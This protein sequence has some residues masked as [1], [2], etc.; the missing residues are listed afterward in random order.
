M[1]TTKKLPPCRT[2]QKEAQFL[3]EV[4]KKVLRVF[5]LAI[6]WNLY[7]F[8]LRF[9]QNHATSYSFYSSVTVHRKGERRE[10]DRKPY[11]LPY[12]LRNPSRNLKF[13][14]TLKIM[15]RNLNEIQIVLS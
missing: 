1:K 8:A 9:L 3:D 10:P 13:E 6:H 12:G 4:K 11:S 2:E 7:S 14:R 5:L 15:P